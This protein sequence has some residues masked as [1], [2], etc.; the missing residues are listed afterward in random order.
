[1]EV[2]VKQV[3]HGIPLATSQMRHY[4][5]EAAILGKRPASLD[6]DGH[7]KGGESDDCLTDLVPKTDANGGATPP[8]ET[9]SAALPVKN[10][11]STYVTIDPAGGSKQCAQP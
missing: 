3:G 9:G 8:P 2:K 7:P 1:M 10:I 5:S 6:C 4:Q 11:P